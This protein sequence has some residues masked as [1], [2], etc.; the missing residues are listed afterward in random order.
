MSTEELRRRFIVGTD[1]LKERLETLVTKTLSHCVVAENGTVHI[2]STS[3]GAKDKVKLVL[4]ARFLAAQLVDDIRSE[5]TIDELSASTGLPDNQIR[6]RANDVV[7][8][9][10]A[11]SPS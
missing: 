2:T 3:L 8:E 4:V 9:R 11:T 7:K 5:V 1:I 6:A 10:F